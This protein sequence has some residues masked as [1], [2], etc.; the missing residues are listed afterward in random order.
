M[1][2]K[3]VIATNP[4]LAFL[5][6][7]PI[8]SS[9]PDVLSVEMKLKPETLNRMGV[10]HGGALATLIDHV[11]GYAVETFLGRGGVTSDLHVRYLTTSTSKVARADARIVRA[12]RTQVVV[13]V[14]VSDHGGR[15]LAIGTLSVMPLNQNPE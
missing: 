15:L 9:A 5:G 13:E 4:L 1:T 6:L 3:E 11:G 10:P 2:H 14:K 12:G 7:S 8:T